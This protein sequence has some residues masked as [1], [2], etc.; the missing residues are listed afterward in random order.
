MSLHREVR[1]EVYRHMVA[2]GAAPTVEEL[3]DAVGAPETDVEA[4]LRR[5]G[6]DRQ[7]VLVP[8]TTKI[9]MAHPFSAVPTLFPV[10]AGDTTYR[11]NCAW[12]A[13]A[14]PALLGRDAE[15]ETRCPDCS[16]PLRLVTRDGELEPTDAVVHFAVPPRRFWVNI[17]FT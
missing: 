16:A 12:D 2:T 6:A 4:A 10:R 3:S 8:G 1:F 7:L 5:L 17:G 9:W 11:A 15:T 14:I 13:M